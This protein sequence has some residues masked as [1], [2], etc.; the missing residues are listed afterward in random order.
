MDVELI[1]DD[2]QVTAPD[3][4]SLLDAARRAG[5]DIPASATTTPCRPSPPAGSAWSRCAGPAATG[6]S[7][8]RRA[9][10]P[11]R[12]GSSW[13]PTRRASAS[14]RAMNLQLLLRRAPEAPVLRRLAERARRDG[15]AVRPRHRRAAARTAS[16][17][18]CACAC[19]RPLGYDALA[20]SGRGVRQ[21]RRSALRPRGRRGLRR[22]RLLRRGLPDRLHR[23]GGHGHHAHDLGPHLRP[24]R[25]RALRQTDHD[26]GAPRDDGPPRSATRRKNDDLCDRLQEAHRERAPR[27]SHEVAPA[28]GKRQASPASSGGRSSVRTPWRR[29]TWR[30]PAESSQPAA[31]TAAS[32]DD[33]GE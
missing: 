25:L 17:A 28:C 22:L 3:G 15:A 2:E 11:C 24:A 20:V 31:A 23:D 6:R 10:T 27:F 1:I 4:S 21:V 30:A 18:S 33:D 32:R 29:R 9:T 14:Y 16:C 12:P 19:A 7:S 5:R 13:S 8:P 26:E